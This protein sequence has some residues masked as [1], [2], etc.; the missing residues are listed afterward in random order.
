[1]NKQDAH[2]LR[3][4]LSWIEDKNLTVT[5]EDKTKRMVLLDKELYNSFLNNYIEQTQPKI[6]NLDPTQKLART[7]SRITRNKLFPEIWKVDPVEASLCPRLF[8]YVKTHKSPL[9]L[10]PLVEKRNAPT[11]NLERVLAKWSMAILGETDISSTTTTRVLEHINKIEWNQGDILATFDYESLY[12][13]LHLEPTCLLFYRFMMENVP[14]A[15]E[16]APLLR[17]IV[18]TICYGSYFKFKEKVHAQVKEFP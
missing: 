2:L 5:R 12:P 7:I 15:Q 14:Q 8:G 6:L 4:I 9:T 17:E 16:R 13:S 3:Q 18:H 11:Y 1:M 10:R